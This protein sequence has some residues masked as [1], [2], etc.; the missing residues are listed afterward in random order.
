MSNQFEQNENS[1]ETKEG[2]FPVVYACVWRASSSGKEA[3][4]AFQDRIPRLMEWLKKLKK[5]GNLVAC[6]GGAF[7]GGPSGGLTLIKATSASK[8]KELSNGTPMNEIGETEV[9]L[10]DLFHA[11]LKQNES[12]GLS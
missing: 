3:D 10:W 7:L 4:D 6:G 11:D 8:A 12:W 9:L 2:E 5:D 1:F